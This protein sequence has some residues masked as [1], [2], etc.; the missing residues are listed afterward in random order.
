[1]NEEFIDKYIVQASRKKTELND[2]ICSTFEKIDFP[3]D[4][5]LPVVQNQDSNKTMLLVAAGFAAIIGAF[6][7]KEKNLV[8][9]PLSVV[10]GAMVLYG[11]IK[12]YQ[13]DVSNKQTPDVEEIDYFNLGQTIFSKVNELGHYV[14]SEWDNFLIEQ[15]NKLKSEI[16]LL[17]INQKDK[18]TMIE[19][20]LFCSVYD[21]SAGEALNVIMNLTN[22]KDLQGLKAYVKTLKENMIQALGNACEEQTRRYK[23]IQEI[24]RS[25]DLSNE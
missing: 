24:Y 14:S 25:S 10:G 16:S 5:E 22:T 19:E 11:L 1:M 6:C 9:I 4:A 17:G 2:L 13:S 18:Q 21:F 3:R 20:A 15:K 23:T 12:K 8:K 7:F